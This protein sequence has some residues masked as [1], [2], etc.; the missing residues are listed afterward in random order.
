MPHHITHLSHTTNSFLPAYKNQP[1]INHKTL[2]PS[3]GPV[4]FGEEGWEKN[5]QTRGRGREWMHIDTKKDTTN[6][7]CNSRCARDLRRSVG[8]HEVIV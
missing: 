2:E 6:T 4:C 7:C 8:I 1:I 5:R 3:L